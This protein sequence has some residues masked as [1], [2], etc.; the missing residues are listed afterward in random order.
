MLCTNWQ[1]RPG[2]EEKQGEAKAH[3]RVVDLRPIYQVRGLVE[4][5]HLLLCQTQQHVANRTLGFNPVVGYGGTSGLHERCY[6]GQHYHAILGVAHH[7]G[8]KLRTLKPIALIL[9]SIQTLEF[10]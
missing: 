7:T 3:V 9:R 10:P 8:R 5:P 6:K 1:K 4:L 2:V